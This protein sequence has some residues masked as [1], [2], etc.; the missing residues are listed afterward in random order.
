MFEYEVY[1]SE[2]QK[3]LDTGADIMTIAPSRPIEIVR[4]GVTV[5]V[6]L[7]NTPTPLT[8]ALDVTPIGGAR[9]EQAETL[10]CTVVDRTVGEVLY[11]V[12]ATPVE[13]EP[14]DLAFL[15]VLSTG[16]GAGDGIP[17]IQYK[18]RGFHPDI[19]N[20]VGAATPTVRV[21]DFTT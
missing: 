4:W 7:D 2:L 18:A 5:T 19:L 14:G 21:Y 11:C 12:P 6:A 10:V 8:M 17:F 16:A 1:E 3:A 13:L 20:D 15:Q 9:T